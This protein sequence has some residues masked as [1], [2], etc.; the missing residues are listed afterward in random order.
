MPICKGL[1]LKFDDACVTWWEAAMLPLAE[2]SVAQH[3]RAIAVAMASLDVLIMG[4]S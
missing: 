1:N 3:A 2:A 4:L